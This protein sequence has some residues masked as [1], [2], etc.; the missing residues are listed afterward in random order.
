MVDFD[1][2]QEK[3]Q[4]MYEARS[5]LRDIQRNLQQLVGWSRNE[6]G[7]VLEWKWYTDWRHNK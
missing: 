3:A 2:D 5:L 4:D 6:L 7:A 1:P